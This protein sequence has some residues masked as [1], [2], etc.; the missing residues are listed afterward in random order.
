MNHFMSHLRMMWELHHSKMAFWNE[1]MYVTHH[2]MCRTEKIGT[3][4]EFWNDGVIMFK[5][6]MDNEINGIIQR[7]TVAANWYK[8]DTVPDVEVRS[9]LMICRATWWQLFSGL[10][11][12]HA[13]LLMCS[14]F[15]A[16]LC[17]CLHFVSSLLLSACMCLICNELSRSG[18]F[19]CRASTHQLYSIVSMS[20]AV[21]V[22]AHDVMLSKNMMRRYRCQ[23]LGN[24]A[25]NS[26]L[27]KLCLDLYPHQINMYVWIL[28]AT[29]PL[30]MTEQELQEVQQVG[31]QV[32]APCSLKVCDRSLLYG[33]SHVVWA[34]MQQGSGSAT[35]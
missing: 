5:T 18:L 11:A 3:R 14:S 1:V 34:G 13:A 9:P 35:M 2:G 20:R 33:R 4:T 21:A 28:Q 32:Y 30:P 27:V 7:C 22:P 24:S 10:M 6:V 26:W 19:T 16:A 17:T 8:Y 12:I 31:S 29:Y 15:E 25:K 23:L